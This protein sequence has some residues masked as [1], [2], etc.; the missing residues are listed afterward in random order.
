[1]RNL[2]FLALFL[3]VP[4]TADAQKP[5]KCS[6]EPADSSLFAAGP[7]YRDCEVDKPAK[8]IGNEPRPAMSSTPNTVR[9]GCFYVEYQFVVNTEG[10][11]EL[12]TV[13]VRRNEM[14]EF[15]EALRATLGQL[16]FQPAMKD[17]VAVRQVVIHRRGLGIATRASGQ[18]FTGAP[19]RCR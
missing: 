3:V 13:E 12:G 15:E 4:A 17:G 18:A 7:I 16:R 1:M 6:G 14:R 19:P 10:Q 8:V 5:K 11:V 9:E 2:L